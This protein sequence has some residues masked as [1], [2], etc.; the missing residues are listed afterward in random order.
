MRRVDEQHK[1]REANHMMAAD[2]T[3]VQSARNEQ[4]E[5]GTYKTSVALA[6]MWPTNPLISIQSAVVFHQITRLSPLGER[7][8]SLL[9]RGSHRISSGCS[10]I[11]T[12]DSEKAGWNVPSGSRCN[13]FWPDPFLGSRVWLQLRVLGVPACRSGSEVQNKDSGLY[14]PRAIGK[15]TTVS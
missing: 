2:P 14:S 5:L 3:P 13:S 7:L 6:G 9:T 15:V 1:L 4:E 12:H 10:G 8:Q 11:E